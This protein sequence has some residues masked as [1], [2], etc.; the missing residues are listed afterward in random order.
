MRDVCIDRNM[1]RILANDDLR[2]HIFSFGEPEHRERMKDVSNDLV[3]RA[4]LI[5]DLVCQDRGDRTA[6][7]YFRDEYTAQ[8]L[9]GWSRYLNRCKCCTRHSHCKPYL[10]WVDGVQ[11][12]RIPEQTHHVHRA[13]I[14]CE[15]PCRNLSRHM[16]KA[17]LSHHLEIDL[18]ID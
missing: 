11:H 17:Y 3:V 10:E 18:E 16:M 15:C 4:D 6:S 12:V 1:E 14:E 9:L 2:R 13:L 7:E 5:R 8:E